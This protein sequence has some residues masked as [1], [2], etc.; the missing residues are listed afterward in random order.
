[1]SLMLLSGT[2]FLSGYSSEFE[3]YPEDGEY[4]VGSDWE[5]KKEL[6][7]KAEKHRKKAVE[8]AKHMENYFSYFPD[9]RD[10]QHMKELITGII[11]CKL[12]ESPRNRILAV[13]VALIASL[14]N[15]SYDKYVYARRTF[16]EITHHFE[17]H[18]FYSAIALTISDDDLKPLDYYEGYFYDAVDYL[19]LA[20][21]LCICIDD[22]SA[23]YDCT[24]WICNHRT[25]VINAFEDKK[26]KHRVSNST[27]TLINKVYDKIGRYYNSDHKSILYNLDCSFNALYKAEKGWEI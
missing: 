6:I 8:K 23:Y 25:Y 10:N 21:I 20:D 9:L 11:T 19:T 3:T 2:M 16:C 18:E 24:D 22:D 4:Y 15:D 26:L 14:A 27:N 12:I 17:M 7:F 13:G 1:M 5:A